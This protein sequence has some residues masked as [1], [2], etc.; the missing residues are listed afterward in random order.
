MERKL[1]GLAIL[2]AL[3]SGCSAQHRPYSWDDPGSAESA[4]DSDPWAEIREYEA[5]D[6]RAQAEAVFA[7][8]SE[9]SAHMMACLAGDEEICL[10]IARHHRLSRQ[11]LRESCAHARS[12]HEG[13][14]YCAL[15]H[16]SV[17]EWNRQDRDRRP[18]AKA[19]QP[20]SPRSIEPRSDASEQRPPDAVHRP[21]SHQPSGASFASAMESVGWVL[22]KCAWPTAKYTR[23]EVLEAPELSPDLPNMQVSVALVRVEG[24]NALTDQPLWAKVAIWFSFRDGEPRP[25]RLQ[26]VDHNALLFAPGTTIRSQFISD[27]GPEVREMVERIC[28]NPP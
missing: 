26:F 6:R 19:E 24:R 21:L 25:V 28:P 7:P 13:R 17:A 23:L 5:A 14:V 10:E 8:P 12:K 18:V 2:I 22:F 16:A 9:G 11:L 15:Y 3:I 20:S 4:S 27:L 1:N